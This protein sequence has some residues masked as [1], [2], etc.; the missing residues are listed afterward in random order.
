MSWLGNLFTSEP[1]T[2]SD[3]R[4]HDAPAFCSLHARSFRRGWSEDEMEQL[5]RDP[6]ITAHRIGSKDKTIGFVLSR[7]AADEAEILSIAVSSRQ[8][9]RG[10]GRQLLMYHMQRLAGLGTKALFLEVEEANAAARRLYQKAGFAQ[11]GRRPSY[12]GSGKDAV[13]A[14]VLRRD[15]T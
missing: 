5:L 11:V 7:R 3:A 4:Q 1:P 10:I 9:G 15:L 13:A 8:R 12:Y 6:Q 2:I 14:L